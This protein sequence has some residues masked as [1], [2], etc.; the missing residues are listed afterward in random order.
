MPEYEVLYIKDSTKKV[1]PKIIAIKPVGWQWG[2]G[3]KKLPFGIAKLELIDKQKADIENYNEY[4][5]DDF[6]KPKKLADT[7]DGHRPFILVEEKEVVSFTDVIDKSI[8]KQVMTKEKHT[9]TSVISG[10]QIPNPIEI[11]PKEV[12]EIRRKAKG[13][14]VNMG[15]VK[16]KI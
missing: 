8:P 3:E 11:L 14:A 15:I 1:Y 5:L 12:K 6:D 2:E 10:R 4:C 16:E 9:I 13:E 7:P